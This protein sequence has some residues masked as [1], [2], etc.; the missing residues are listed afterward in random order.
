MGFIANIY[1]DESSK[2]LTDK[3]LSRCDFHFLN[4]TKQDGPVILKVSGPLVRMPSSTYWINIEPVLSFGDITLQ[5][6]GLWRSDMFGTKRA[7]RIRGTKINS[8]QNQA[9]K[10]LPFGSHVHNQWNPYTSGLSIEDWEISRISKSAVA[11]DHVHWQNETNLGLEF[12]LLALSICTTTAFIL[13]NWFEKS[14]TRF[15]GSMS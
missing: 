3:N 2:R 11:K 4:P 1:H 12:S 14:N 5:K 6:R 13:S 15:R 10:N 8:N 9:R 7:Q